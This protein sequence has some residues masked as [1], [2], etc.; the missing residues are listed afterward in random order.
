MARIP[1]VLVFLFGVVFPIFGVVVIVWQ[2]L[3]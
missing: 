3:F 2:A 1:T